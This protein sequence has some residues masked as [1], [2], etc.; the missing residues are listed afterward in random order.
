MRQRSVVSFLAALAIGASSFV[1][2]S[3][4]AKE[5]VQEWE[6]LNPAGVVEVKP[7]QLAP[8]ITTLEGKT[9]VLR[10]NNK[11]NGNNF[12]DRIAELL[13]ANV[14]SAKVIKLYEVDP[15]TIKISGSV[16]ESARI[17]KVIKGLH[18]DLVIGN[19]AD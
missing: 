9:I 10:W 3:A 19:Q 2:S 14:P 13:K 17:A 11:H 4:V 12:L 15:S 5:A 16:E 1:P 7:A 8:R 6:F 18:A